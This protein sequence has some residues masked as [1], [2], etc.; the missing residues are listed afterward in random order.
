MK[1]LHRLKRWLGHSR[2]CDGQRRNL[3]I[4][5]PSDVMA[6]WAADVAAGP[7]PVQRRDDT[8]TPV[9]GPDSCYGHYDA[10]GLPRGAQ[11]GC[12]GC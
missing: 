9:C 11:R 4:T 10:S 5:S 6:L 1:P 8:Q 2:R 12:G 7:A 3:T